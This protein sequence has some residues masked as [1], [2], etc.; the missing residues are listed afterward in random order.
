MNVCVGITFRLENTLGKYLQ[1]AP[2]NLNILCAPQ[3]AV[4]VIVVVA[5]AVACFFVSNYL[6]QLA[7]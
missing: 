2:I 7:V 3:V 6:I 4:A 5:V 1:A